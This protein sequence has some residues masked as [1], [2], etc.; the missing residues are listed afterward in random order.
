MGRSIRLLSPTQMAVLVNG[1]GPMTFMGITTCVNSV[2]VRPCLGLVW[3]RSFSNT[4]YYVILARQEEAQNSSD[5]VTTDDLA[6]KNGQVLHLLMNS[7]KVAKVWGLSN[8]DSN[9]E[10]R[11][12]L[13][14]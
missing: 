12:G 4:T 13:T 11:G 8:P 1:W 7:K 3:H 9:F 2:L 6:G 5:E 14:T 10:H